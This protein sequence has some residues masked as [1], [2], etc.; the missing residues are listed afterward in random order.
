MAV[1][2]K[3]EVWKKEGGYIWS[4][5]GSA[6]GFA[7]VLSF[8]SLCYKNGGGA[9][10]IPYILA[11]LVIGVP[12]LILEAVIGQRTKLPFVSAMGLVGGRGAKAI[13]WISILTCAT[14]GG[15]YVVLTGYSV[16]YAYFTATGAIGTDTAY[17][18]KSVFLQ[19]SGS[20]LQSGTVAIGV[21]ASTILVLAF[22]WSILSRNI[23]AGV[24]KICSLFMPLL[25][26][27]IFLFSF[28]I[29]VLPGAMEGVAHYLTPDFSRLRDWSLWRDV[30][31]Q[32]FFSLSLGLGIVTG[33]SRHNPSTFRLRSA[34][35][36]VAIGDFVISFI[37]G[38]A[39][40]GCIGF[41]SAKSGTPFHLL[42][43]SD[44]AFEIGFVIF[45]NILA[46]FGDVPS[47]VIGPLFFFCVFIAGITGFFSI[48][49]SVAGNIEVEFRKTRKQSVAIAMLTIGV[50]AFPFCMGNG[51]HILGGLAP[52]V[53]GNSMLMGGIMEI[54]LFLLFSAMIR[55]E[56][57]WTKE[58]G[59]KVF[60]YYAL[61]CVVL[62]LL[63][64][65]LAG[66]LYQEIKAGL[67]AESILRFAWLGMV[68]LLGGIFSYRSGPQVALS[69][70]VHQ[71]FG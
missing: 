60:P 54:V 50:L 52:M 47:R 37:A 13:G 36:K 48:V 66:A 16:A 62:P 44:S 39:V 43:T 22:S 4:M 65:S 49:E 63:I 1:G 71:E 38:F 59:G 69:E 18:F 17:F 41:M 5:I 19:D 20:L 15:F 57:I 56:P 28:V 23:H 64:L 55:E 58:G 11:H 3:R 8:S 6:V 12:T 67:T 33:Y 35:Y 9:F 26:V 2:N 14:I 51:Q 29:L 21:L 40:F 46:Q 31:A 68:V 24:E 53:V 25:G 27:L 45:P 10:L 70:K 34:M 32:V 61:R 7:N 42:V 30:F